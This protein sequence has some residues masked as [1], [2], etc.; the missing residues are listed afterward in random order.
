M[1]MCDTYYAIL[2]M[3]SYKILLSFLHFKH[4]KSR[5]NI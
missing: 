5:L 1:H 2:N 3:Y 4:N